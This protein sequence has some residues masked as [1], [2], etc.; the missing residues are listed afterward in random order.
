MGP[1]DLYGVVIEGRGEI[2]PIRGPRHCQLVWRSRIV[3]AG[4][5]VGENRKPGGGTPD[6]HGVIA[7][8]SRGDGFSQNSEAEMLMISPVREAKP[9]EERPIP[10]RTHC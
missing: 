4:L 9:R 2:L 1:P 8:D 10:A 3:R 7:Q 6:P 5:T